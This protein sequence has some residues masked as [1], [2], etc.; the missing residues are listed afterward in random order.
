MTTSI[1][2]SVSVDPAEVARF[3]AIAEEWWSPTGK[4]RPLHAIN[5]LRLGFIRDEV[6]AH[7]GLNAE[8][9]MPLVGLNVLDIG[10][11]GGLLCE[12]V[13]RLG[14]K[15]TGVDASE[16][17]IRIASLHAEQSGV[18]VIYRYM[19]AEELLAEGAEF[20]IVLNMEVIEHVADVPAFMEASCA[21]VKP[22][23]MMF[24]ATLNRTLKSLALAKIGAEYIL[25]WL[26]RGT[27]DWS[28]FLRPSEIAEQ[29]RQQQMEVRQVT[30]MIY[31][32]LRDEWSLS[33]HDLAVNYLM[34]AIKPKG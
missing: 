27:H 32:P 23:G 12:P 29:L 10:C 4:F 7:F 3:A 18:E 31:H 33:P 13:S 15:V 28:K 2:R 8:A 17:N 21:L 6:C 30:G 19:T 9:K 25:R 26:P 11:G 1:S 34:S 16:K 14:A 24:M 22:G 20:D 5:P